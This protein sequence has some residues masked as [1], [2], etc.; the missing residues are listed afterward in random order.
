[1]T[2]YCTK[3]NKIIQTIPYPNDIKPIR[4]CCCKYKEKIYIIDGEN[5]EIIEFDPFTQKYTKKL[6]IP[7][8]GKYASAV[9]VFDNIHILHGLRN[10]KHLVYNV[11]K[12]E[13]KAI[14]DTDV[15]WIVCALNYSNRI[16][17]FAGLS[18][19]SVKL[20]KFVM[21]SVIEQND[22]DNDNND[23]T[24]SERPEF[25]LKRGVYQFGYVLYKHYLIFFGGDIGC[26][27]FVDTIY[28]LDLNKNIGWIELQH[29]KCPMKSKY[30]AILTMDKHVHLFSG[31]NKWPD[32][33][34]S[35]RGHY[36]IPIST[37]L[38]SQFC[39]DDDDQH[40]KFSIEN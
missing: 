38:G 36:S 40:N 27:D 28:L 24:W 16:I 22:N 4:H 29:I 23:I 20:D 35:E 2:E 3:T 31:S 12:N 13:I 15:L 37:I 19:N 18:S 11:T 17:K 1:M 30:V 21:S 5:D 7:K 9:T 25:K 26:G 34:N 32:W 14:A 10:N 8:I 39:I 33:P 6:K